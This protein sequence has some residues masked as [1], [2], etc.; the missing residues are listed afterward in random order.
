[1]GEDAAV[2]VAGTVTEILT[3]STFRVRLDDDTVVLAYA[4]GKIRKTL[5]TAAVGDRVHVQLAPESPGRGRI[6]R[7]GTG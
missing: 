3:A 6:L 1:V 5:M 7:Q 4:A 2:D